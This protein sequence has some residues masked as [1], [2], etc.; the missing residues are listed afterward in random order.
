MENV[1][2]ETEMVVGHATDG[3]TGTTKAAFTVLE[4]AKAGIAPVIKA[5]TTGAGAVVMAPVKGLG[6]VLGISVQQKKTL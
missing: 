5:A 4:T 2:K 3:L 1:W 6:K